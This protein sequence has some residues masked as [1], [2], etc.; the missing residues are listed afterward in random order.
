M[1]IPLE[2]VRGSMLPLVEVD[3]AQYDALFDIA[4]DCVSEATGV[5][6]VEILGTIR[7]DRIIFARFA[8]YKLVRDE[9]CSYYPPRFTWIASKFS[10]AGKK[11]SGSGGKHHG[12]IIHGIDSFCNRISTNPKEFKLYSLILGK[13]ELRRA[14]HVGVEVMQRTHRAEASA[15]KIAAARCASAIKNNEGNLLGI[16]KRLAELEERKEGE[17]ESL[18]QDKLASN[19]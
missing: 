13:F 1:E 16:M 7:T 19:G 2:Q 14:D 15:L 3:L 18:V 12:S 5:N 11:G 9:L 8:V 10:G 4:I 17:N 6:R